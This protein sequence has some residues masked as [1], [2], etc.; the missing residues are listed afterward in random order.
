MVSLFFRKDYIN[1]MTINTETLFINTKHFQNALKHCDT[2][3]NTHLSN[4]DLILFVLNPVS[5]THLRA[6]ET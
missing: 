1:T 2:K 3:P 6:H 4:R 5:Y